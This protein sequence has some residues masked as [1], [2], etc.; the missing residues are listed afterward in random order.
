MTPPTSDAA[1]PQGPLVD[2]AWLA[3]HLGDDDVVVADVRQ[4]VDGR[5]GRDAFADGHVPGAVFLDLDTDLAALPTEGPGRHPLPAP[6]R[7]AFT[8]RAI[9]VERTTTVV[10]YDDARGSLA[11]RLWWLLDVQGCRAV[12][13][14][15]GLAAWVAAGHPL[16]QGP[17]TP[18][19]SSSFTAGPW[20][21]AR[22]AD[23]DDVAAARGADTVVLDARVPE[24]YR[25]DNE[26]FDARAGH[27]PGAR[28]A[29]WPA[30][31]DPATG[32]FLPREV[33]RRRYDEL[34]GGTDVI[35]YCGSG[36]TACHD[37]V[38]M[39]AAGLPDARLYEGSWSDWSSDPA[40][41]VAVGAEP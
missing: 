21:Q 6:E 2:A 19:R 4:S 28:N 8:M 30:N 1:A 37:L 13:L 36:I 23:A 25:S 34:C 20:P 18:R 15:G 29:P 40:R 3:A 27:V 10:A 32:R 7:F 39:R 24:R 12:L 9:G 38:A 5:A 16:E 31:L 33:L 14:D 22:V 11:A 35:V 17:P 41:P 26:P